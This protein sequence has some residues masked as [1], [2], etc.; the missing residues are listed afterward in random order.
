MEDCEIAVE[1]EDLMC[2]DD[3]LKSGIGLKKHKGTVAQR[4]C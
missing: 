1:G 4:N 3:N 2:Y